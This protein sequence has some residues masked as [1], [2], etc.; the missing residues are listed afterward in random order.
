MLLY[1]KVKSVAVL[2]LL[3][4]QKR[5]FCKKAYFNT[6]KNFVVLDVTFTSA[7]FHNFLAYASVEC[8]EII[9]QFGTNYYLQNTKFLYGLV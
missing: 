4:V 1:R 2:I 6:Y 7:L 8:K 9:H 3:R 5:N